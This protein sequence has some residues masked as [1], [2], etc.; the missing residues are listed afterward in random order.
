M[1]EPV[2]SKLRLPARLR[3]NHWLCY[4][5]LCPI[6]ARRASHDTAGIMEPEP[7]TRTLRT[8]ILLTF[9]LSMF[10]C[11]EPLML[12]RKGSGD[13]WNAPGTWEGITRDDSLLAVAHTSLRSAAFARTLPSRMEPEF[14]RAWV[15]TTADAAWPDARLISSTNLETPSGRRVTEVSL[16]VGEGDVTHRHDFYLFE[17]KCFFIRAGRKTGF[18]HTI[19]LNVRTVPLIVSDIGKQNIAPS[20]LLLPGDIFNIF[21]LD[22]G[23]QVVGGHERAITF[24]SV[25]PSLIP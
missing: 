14:A 3:R 19:E 18:R 21:C 6:V 12:T 20:I 11:V 5:S 15:L 10:A 8:L 16:D 13:A 9:A 17:L 22:M 4:R 7:V 25:E 23:R 24:D 1:G 2:P